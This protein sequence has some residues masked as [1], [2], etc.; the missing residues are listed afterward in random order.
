MNYQ[1]TK[2]IN[3]HL[4]IC[5]V[6]LATFLGNCSAREVSI[7]KESWDNVQDAELK[8]KFKEFIGEWSLTQEDFLGKV[9]KGLTSYNERRKINSNP[10][11]SNKASLV[12]FEVPLNYISGEE[13]PFY[14]EVFKN[15]LSK[16]SGMLK[17]IFS[18]LLISKDSVKRNIRR[19]DASLYIVACFLEF[20]EKVDK[21]LKNPEFN[22]TELIK[23]LKEL[24]NGFHDNIQMVDRQ[25]KK[26]LVKD[27]HKV[28]MGM[29]IEPNSVEQGKIVFVENKRV[30]VSKEKTYSINVRCMLPPKITDYLY[31]RYKEIEVRINR[32]DK[33]LQEAARKAAQEE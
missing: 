26:Y 5:L 13:N 19:R 15:E 22:N 25:S 8:K 31:Q 6:A 3:Q 23:K 9:A 20:T 27:A 30:D 12:Q 24:L 17:T 11:S 2:I 28:A 21:T 4:C 10:S 33:D 14:E 7:L 1:S 16:I 32:L 29:M 18:R